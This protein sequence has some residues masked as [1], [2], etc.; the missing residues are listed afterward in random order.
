MRMVVELDKV[1]WAAADYDNQR[2]RAIACVRGAG[3][4]LQE[5]RVV[6]TP[7]ARLPF[8]VDRHVERRAARLVRA[9][10]VQLFAARR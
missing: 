10:R 4:A 8:E 6:I 5:P 7:H 9:A 3:N 2:R 1:V